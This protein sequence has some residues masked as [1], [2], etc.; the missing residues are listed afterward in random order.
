MTAP[1]PRITKKICLLG[2]TAV[3]K[4]S[5]IQQFVTGTFDESY[6]TTI[7]VNIHSMDVLSDGQPVRLMIWDLEG[8][9]DPRKQYRE[10]YMNGAHG[11]LLVIDVTRAETLDIA[12]SLHQIVQAMVA[13]V[14]FVALLNKRDLLSRWELRADEVRQLSD[15]GWPVSETSAKTGENVREAFECLTRNMLAADRTPHGPRR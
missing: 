2:A 11:Y 10:D 15:E 9:D 1:Q 6:K 14:P 3:G 7:G 8:Q 13:E 12:R 5:L 4:S